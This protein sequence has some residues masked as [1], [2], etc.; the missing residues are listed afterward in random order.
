MDVPQ[1]G[2]ELSIPSTL[3]TNVSRSIMRGLPDEVV[4]NG[5]YAPSPVFSRYLTQYLGSLGNT[6]WGFVGRD[7]TQPSAKVVGIA[8]GVITLSQVLAGVA[9]G[10]YLRLN[11]V[12]D[13]SRE[14]VRG[15]FQ[16]TAIAG[17]NYT[18]VGLKDTTVT[19]ISGTARKDTLVKFNYAIGT[20]G[21]VVVRKIGRP[22][23]GYRGRRSKQRIKQLSF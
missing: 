9:V 16:I 14:S 22:F 12:Y 4:I 15:A 7:L 11:K 5:E 1:A 3:F 10:D 8:A 20:F 13:V 23:S 18:C 19:S 21:R 6:V 2:L 17:A